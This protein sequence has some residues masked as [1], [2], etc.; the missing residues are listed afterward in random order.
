M[1]KISISGKAN[2]GKNTT[3]RFLKQEIIERG[4]SLSLNL[5]P[6]IMA[7]A[8][9]IKEMA[10]IM[11]PNL[12]RKFLYG[13]SKYRSEIIPGAFKDGKPLTVRQ[14]LIDIGTKLGRNYNDSIWLN[15]F[16]HRLKKIE[17]K[18]I[19]LSDLRFRNEFDHLKSKG[20]FQIRLIRDEELKLDDISETQ[21]D[22]IKD[23][24]FDFILKN[25]DG[26]KEL[27]LKIR[28]IVNKLP[29]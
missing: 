9:P 1:F 29:G 21:Q 16:D 18:P 3:A 17:N 5:D 4:K 22:L 11:F 2:S 7:F 24:E 27:K 6:K 25:N 26:L 8:D 13:S 23:E 28:D 19:I 15:N 20:F 10:R 14:V 12:P